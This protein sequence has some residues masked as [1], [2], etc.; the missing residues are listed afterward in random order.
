MTRFTRRRFVAAAAAMTAVSWQP[1]AIAQ[2]AP[3]FQRKKLPIGLQLYTLAELA[4]RDLEGTLKAIYEIG[5]R[6]VELAGF[7]GRTG[8]QLRQAFDASGL[9]CTAAHVQGQGPAG[10][11]LSG[12]LAQLAKELRIIGV[13]QVIM[14]VFNVPERLGGP[15]PGEGFGT[16]LGRVGMQFTRA[17]WQ[18]NAAFLN[19]KAAGLQREGLRL[20]YH[21]HNSE[22]APLPDGS[23]GLEVLLE[24]TDPALIT[25]ELDVGWVTAAG[26]DPFKLLN[27]HQGRFA[28]MHVK[29]VKR[30]TVANYAFKQDPTEVG[31]GIIDWPRLLTRAYECGVRKFFVEQEPPFERER[32]D[33]VRVSYEYL[34]KVI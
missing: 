11:S 12:D 21:N 19:E 8:A 15:R 1:T 20:G 14:P 9:T 13:T 30:S 2:S 26:H 6:D 31:R 22:F 7:L 24:E 32:I 16:Y 10:T 33:A 29:D 17:D 25:F 28:L 3:F 4:T 34:R 5:Y 18:R 23:T 27:K